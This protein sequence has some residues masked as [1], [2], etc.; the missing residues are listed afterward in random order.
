M[1]AAIRSTLDAFVGK[2]I[3]VTGAIDPQ[4]M[5]FTLPHEHIMSTFGAES[6]RYPEYAREKLFGA[7]LPYL[8]QIRGFGCQTLVD[9]TATHFGR[10]PEFLREISR[11]SNVTILTNTGYYGAAHDRYVPSYAFGETADQIAAR[12]V[13]EW[14]YGI[15]DT[16]V[17]PG[18]I[19]TAVDEGQLSEIDRKLIIAA[20]KTH[21]QTG[22]TIQ[23]HTGNN[24]AAV[25]EIVSILQQEGVH[26]NAWIWVHAHQEQDSTRLAQA[27]DQ[28][29]WVS[30]DGI[31]AE[32]GAHILQLILALKERSHLAHVLLSH[33]GDSYFGDGEFRPYD[34]LF[35]DFIPQLEQA[36]LSNDEIRQLTVDNP[37]RAFTV[38]VRLAQA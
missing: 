38:G 4:E 26:P 22:L 20:A 9:C 19:K 3:T 13:R 27:A 8:S 6:A 7:V 24:W 29:A 1:D 34:Y 30:L 35:T 25:Q 23:T 12:W 32:S 36:G 2:V 33:D 17:R 11:R 37:C 14:V 18:F 21:L 5:G 16:G 15:D 31:A 10:H 28:G